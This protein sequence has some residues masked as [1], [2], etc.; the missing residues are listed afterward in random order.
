MQPEVHLQQ[1]NNAT[2]NA[3][4]VFQMLRKCARTLQKT[5][6][7]ILFEIKFL[8]CWRNFRF[9]TQRESGPGGG[10]SNGELVIGVPE[11]QT[12]N[13]LDLG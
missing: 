12:T 13:G 2:R 3:P 4:H 6:L 1:K 9:L 10:A 8:H 7:I 11:V 5:C